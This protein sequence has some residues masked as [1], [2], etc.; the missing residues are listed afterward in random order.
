MA[1]HVW[2]SSKYL[3]TKADAR[4][5]LRYVFEEGAYPEVIASTL[6]DIAKARGGITKLARET[7][8]TRMTLYKIINGE[9]QPSFPTIQKILRAFGLK[10]IIQ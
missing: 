1:V 8:L 7:G 9:T 4:E 2:D 5:V 10:I 6:A 3:K